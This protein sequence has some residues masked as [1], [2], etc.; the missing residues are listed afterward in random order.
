MLSDI[1]KTQ[2][3][4]SKPAETVR[5]APELV[6]VPAVHNLRIQRLYVNI[7]V[8]TVENNLVCHGI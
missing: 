7:V 1:P 4:T 8:N 6:A 2:L 5:Q 3:K